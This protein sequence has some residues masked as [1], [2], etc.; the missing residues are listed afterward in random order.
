MNKLEEKELE[1][2]RE[3]QKN[4]AAIV[5]DLGNIELQK[6]SLLHV[7]A[8]IQNAQEATK[9]ELEE[10][11]GKINVNLEDGTFEEVKAEDVEVVE[12]EV[13]EG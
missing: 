3:Q 12:P 9:K 7:F 5:S 4:K 10:K 6:H 13:V 11:Y 1:V 8:E 2:L